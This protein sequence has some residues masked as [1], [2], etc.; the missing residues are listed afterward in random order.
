MSNIWQHWKSTLAGIGLAALQVLE[1]GRSGKQIAIAL[2]TAVLGAVVK[3][4]SS[5]Q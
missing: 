2:A 3:D 5:K 4:P 1:N